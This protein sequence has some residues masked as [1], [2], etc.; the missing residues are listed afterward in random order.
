MSASSKRSQV[1]Q[2]YHSGH[3]L[4]QKCLY[5]E[6]LIVLQQAEK[7][8]RASDARGHPL[9]HSLSNG[10]SGLANT[11]VVSGFC[12]QKLE[13]FKAALTCFETSLV[14][15]RF[16]KKRA[17]RDFTKTFTGD[18]IACYEQV[19]KT[20]VDGTR[21][22]VPNHDPE[23]DISFQFPYSLPPDAI[24]FARLYELDPE[25]HAH[26]RDFHRRAKEK[27]S[28]IRRWSKSSDDSMMKRTSIY[29]WGILFIIGASYGIIVMD[30]LLNNNK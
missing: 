22:L 27:D 30:A 15:S 21:D 14:N 7:A 16:E 25:H 11:L 19:L 3:T 20:S 12:H 1:E 5:N 23:I 10:V 24:P 26:Y 8:F 18:L 28:E 6:A 17:F 4:Y 13:N 2:L 29:V 9:I